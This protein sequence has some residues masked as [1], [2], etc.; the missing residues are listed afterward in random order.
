MIIQQNKLDAHNPALPFDE[1]D[2]CS[3]DESRYRISLN[4]TWKFHW[5]VNA[6]VP[7]ENFFKVGRY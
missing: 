2:V 5:H 4:G 7:V 1:S 3:F 6:D